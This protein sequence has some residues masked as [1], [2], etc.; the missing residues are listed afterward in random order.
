VR[1]RVAIEHSAVL[2]TRCSSSHPIF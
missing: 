2:G 1:V